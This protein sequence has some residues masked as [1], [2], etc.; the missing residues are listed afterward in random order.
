MNTIQ[1]MSAFQMLYLH[2]HLVMELAGCRLQAAVTRLCDVTPILPCLLA[3]TFRIDLVLGFYIVR[4]VLQDI[5]R[6]AEGRLLSDRDMSWDRVTLETS[7]IITMV[8]EPI[9]YPL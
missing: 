3:F 6:L 8:S 2:T 4:H 5:G 1:P 7:S 9:S